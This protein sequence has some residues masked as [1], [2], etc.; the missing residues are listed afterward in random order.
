MR[1]LLLILLILGYIALPVLSADADLQLTVKDSRRVIIT[2]DALTLDNI[3]DDNNLDAIVV[4]KVGSLAKFRTFSGQGD[5]TFGAFATE[6]SLYLDPVDVVT[7][8]FNGDNITD[9]AALNNAC[10]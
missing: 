9:I 6:G 10:G 5:G 7:G 2:P 3:T 8:D 4:G 1:V